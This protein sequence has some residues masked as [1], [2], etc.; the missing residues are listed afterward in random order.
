MFNRLQLGLV[1]KA[2]HV[3]SG[4]GCQRISS[5]VIYG[6]QG[7]YM[8]TQIYIDQYEVCLSFNSMSLIMSFHKYNKYK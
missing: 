1:G 6:Y 5:K 2:P 7:K 4:A 3:T 8:K